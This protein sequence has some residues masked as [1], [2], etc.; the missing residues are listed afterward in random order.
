MF[1]T[2]IGNR[3]PYGQVLHDNANNRN[4]GN[5]KTTKI[6]DEISVWNCLRS[7]QKDYF[8]S[9]KTLVRDQSQYTES[10]NAQ[11][12]NLS[13]TIIDE[14]EIENKAFKSQ[15]CQISR[16]LISMENDNS[17]LNKKMDHA[18]SRVTDLDSKSH[19]TINEVLS[20]INVSL[21][22][23]SD[24]SF[25]LYQESITHTNQLNS[26]IMDQTSHLFDIL[27]SQ[28]YEYIGVTDEKS[29]SIIKEQIRTLLSQ[30]YEYFP[31]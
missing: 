25:R 13:N 7:V 20:E 9:K 2:K 24:Y 21:K 23:Q 3:M 14:L 15:I 10:L 22:H 18:I 1:R 4:C 17:N 31:G 6:S 16:K 28:I 12:I 26:V 30:K 19:E 11:I 8:D 5:R 27:Y 29:L